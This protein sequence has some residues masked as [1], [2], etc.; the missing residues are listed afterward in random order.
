M[1]KS[2]KPPVEAPR[3]AVEREFERR[4]D[5]IE[6]RLREQRRERAREVV[7]PL[8]LLLQFE[9]AEAPRR[10]FDPGAREVAE[11]GERFAVEQARQHALREGVA[12]GPVGNEGL[13][14]L[15][16]L[17]AFRE[18][19]A[20]ALLQ[21]VAA[22]I[23]EEAD[24]VVQRDLVELR[25]GLGERQRE[26]SLLRFPRLV[27]VLGLVRL[28]AGTPS[29]GRRAAGA[30]RLERG[31]RRRRGQPLLQR[32]AVLVVEAAAA[33]IGIRLEVVDREGLQ[34]MLD[35]EPLP[36]G[37]QR[38][39]RERRVVDG[40]G[41]VVEQLRDQHRRRQRRVV[42][43]AP[44]RVAQVQ[45]LARGE[46]EVEEHVALVDAALAVAAARVARH[47]VEFAGALRRGEGA[48]VQV[49]CAQTKR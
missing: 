23:A 19:D 4:A 39:R 20:E 29:A 12:R 36:R 38:F 16:F 7:E 47:Q 6:L 40:R 25:A 30:S 35:G 49:R 33:R 45:P 8:Q 21:Q 5:G 44:S 31:R 48:V 13:V 24:E 32:L 1:R 22:R 26:E 2:P 10:I 3:L 11:L 37:L 9:I 27:L 14:V 43:H 41:A 15:Q 17:V 18:H 46:E 28:V 42:A 34:R